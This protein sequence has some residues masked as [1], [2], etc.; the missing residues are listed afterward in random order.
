M[1]SAPR[2]NTVCSH[3]FLVPRYVFLALYTPLRSFFLLSSSHSCRTNVSISFFLFYTSF[4]PRNPGNSLCTLSTT[5]D[6]AV[7][8]TSSHYPID[9]LLYSIIQDENESRMK[10]N[11]MWFIMESVFCLISQWNEGTQVIEHKGYWCD[12]VL[13]LSPVLA[14]TFITW[15]LF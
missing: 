2:S 7:T 3:L 5:T 6:C 11:E 10:K 4:C 9:L 15:V 13:R 8:H 14:K 1:F 12:C